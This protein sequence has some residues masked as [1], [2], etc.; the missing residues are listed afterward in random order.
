LQVPQLCINSELASC[1]Q[2]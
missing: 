1:A 2:R